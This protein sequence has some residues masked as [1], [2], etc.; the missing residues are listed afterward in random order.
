[1]HAILA[2]YIRGR[3]L[4]LDSLYDAIVETDA[5]DHYEPVYSINEEGWWLHRR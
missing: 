3:V 2:V 5:I 4:I 1:M